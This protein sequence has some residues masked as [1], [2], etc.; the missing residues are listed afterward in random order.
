MKH[1]LLA[2]VAS[3]GFSF[4]A[5]SDSM[6]PDEVMIQHYLSDKFITP[7]T[8]QSG[9]Q[10][11]ASLEGYTYFEG[12]YFPY[13]QLAEMLGLSILRDESIYSFRHQDIRYAV[14]TSR[15]IAYTGEARQLI[16]QV[17]IITTSDELYLHEAFLENWL[18][19][20]FMVN[21]RGKRITLPDS[22]RDKTVTPAET[23]IVIEDSEASA[24]LQQVIRA[25][26]IRAL[27]P[28][29]PE[30]RAAQNATIAAS[31]T[32]SAV[33]TNK[34]AF[35]Q[36]LPNTPARITPLSKPQ[37]HRKATAKREPNRLRTKPLYASPEQQPVRRNLRESL[38]MV[39]YRYNTPAAM[40]TTF[41]N[42]YHVY[43]PLTS[44]MRQFDLNVIEKAEHIF[45]FH[46]GDVQHAF[47]LDV[48]NKQITRHK[49]SVQ[50]ESDQLFWRDG[51][52]Y[53]STA[54]LNQCLPQ[55]IQMRDNYYLE[56]SGL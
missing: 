51:E 29:G 35:Q 37:K 4:S 36:A 47:Y 44:L 40:V 15:H 13:T 16:P 28:S 8:V 11:M 10:D 54:L 21:V 42:E 7:Y 26:R 52:L 30:I 50:I 14:D 9:T 17:H 1:I 12:V 2:T 22:N 56:L 46:P 31:A 3:L 27:P 19:F 18:P 34:P 43:L 23:E 32:V 39:H 5:S 24:A 41:Y 20:D 6:I 48:H 25:R 38:T 55:K 53:L 49:Q 33:P 45:H